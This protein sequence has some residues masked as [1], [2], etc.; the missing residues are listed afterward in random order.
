MILFLQFVQFFQFKSYVR[1]VNEKLGWYGEMNIVK[2][3]ID[4]GID[5]REKDKINEI[6]YIK[7]YKNC[8]L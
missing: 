1:Q 6:I 7:E 2:L 4:I 8:V 5:I 3:M